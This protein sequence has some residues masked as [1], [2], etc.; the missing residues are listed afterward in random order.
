[1]HRVFR[2]SIEATA[3]VA[4]ALSLAAPANA[5]N[6]SAVGAGLFDRRW[7]VGWQCSHTTNGVCRSATARL[8]CPTSSCLCRARARLCGA[9]ILLWAI[10]L[11]R[12]STLRPVA[13]AFDSELRTS[14]TE[15]ATLSVLL[16]AATSL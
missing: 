2:V 5:G 16:L 10:S 15:A 6:G 7:S 3:I 9:G 13:L 8:L 4:A 14:A 12:P 11:S 1:M